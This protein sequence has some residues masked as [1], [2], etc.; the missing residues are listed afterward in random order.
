MVRNG[1]VTLL[2]ALLPIAAGFAADNVDPAL[3]VNDSASSLLADARCAEVKITNAPEVTCFLS[4]P[5]AVPNFFYETDSS[6]SQ[7]IVKLLDTRVGG[8]VKPGKTD[9]V[10][11]GPVATMTVREEIQDKNA[12]VKLL[13]PEYY[14]VTIVTITC[15]PMIRRQ[16]DLIV[17]QMENVISLSFPWPEKPTDRK[18]FYML[19][20]KKRRPALLLSI[21]GV[22]VAGLAGGGYYAYS[23]GYLSSPEEVSQPLE[24]VLP[25][26]PIP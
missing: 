6:V 18:K 1:M 10:S 9:T 24:P 3:V 15:N 26:H 12:T 21:I 17:S 20:G 23:H 22:A 13:T 19:A 4:F 16:N 11:L 5:G 25:E 8:M 7:V 2:T 14:Y